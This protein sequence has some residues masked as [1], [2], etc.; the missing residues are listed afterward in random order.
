MA[1]R[2]RK[3]KTLPLNASK[4]RVLRAVELRL[5]GQTIEQ[6][7]STMKWSYTYARKAITARMTELA[8][9]REDQV[10]EM[11]A[12]VAERNMRM[13]RALMPVAAPPAVLECPHCDNAQYFPPGSTHCYA[14][15]GKVIAKGPCT[16]A[17]EQVR[18][19]QAEH[20]KLFGLY[21]PEKIEVNLGDNHSTFDPSKLSDEELEQA[22]RLASKATKPRPVDDPGGKGT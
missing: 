4:A 7:A 11:R 9:E 18:K 17:V 14:C 2:K 10:N 21:A 13:V 1:T 6:I 8:L 19:I 3:T 15:N 16:K 5:E 22:E 12:E 20:A